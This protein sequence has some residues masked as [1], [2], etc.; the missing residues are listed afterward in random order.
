[1]NP[2]HSPNDQRS[3]SS[4][5]QMQY[6]S[7]SAAQYPQHPQSAASSSYVH[8]Q[9]YYTSPDQHQMAYIAS[10]QSYPQLPSSH[11]MVNSTSYPGGSGQQGMP[12][13]YSNPRSMSSSGGHASYISDHY[14][15]QYQSQYPQQ[16][17][18]HQQQQMHSPIGQRYSSSPIQVL[19]HDRRA[20]TSPTTPYASPHSSYPSSSHHHH[21]HHHHH[22]ST[23]SHGHTQLSPSPGTERFPC[24]K[25]DKTFSRSHDR[26]RHYESQHSPQPTSHRCPFCHKE[27]SRADS[28]KRHVDNGCEKDPSYACT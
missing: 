23:S 28:M 6:S 15:A 16:A 22:T 27:F 3:L 21:H 2:Q 12:L 20:S 1:M 26:K 10:Q 24:D 19:Q 8:Q 18:S 17:V 14:T 7:A 25:C 13:A 9:Q 11:P 5:T 4:T